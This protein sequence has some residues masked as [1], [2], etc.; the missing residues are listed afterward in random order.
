M[1]GKVKRLSK[2]AREL[3]VGISTL[4]EFLKTKEIEVDSSP[5]TKLDPE[6]YAILSE[7]FADDQTLKEEAEKAAIKREKRKTIS[8]KTKE[9]ESSKEDDA[10]IETPVEQPVTPEAPKEPEAPAVEAEKEEKEETPAP[11][12]KEEVKE[13]SKEEAEEEKPEPKKEDKAPKL[14][15]D[16]PKSKDE[17][18]GG[19]NVIG[20]IDLSNIDTR[21]RPDKKKKDK[22]EDDKA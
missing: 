21:T 9:E 2:V 5:N 20:K 10:E 12:A 14:I 3:N 4:V 1:A 18:S 17:N 15:K 6:H 13:E 8:L 11:A 22:K 7:E 16:E 19:L